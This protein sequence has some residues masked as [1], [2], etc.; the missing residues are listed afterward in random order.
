MMF[1]GDRLKP[2]IKCKRRTKMLTTTNSASIFYFRYTLS[3]KGIKLHFIETGEVVNKSQL[4][5]FR[6]DN[7]TKAE[8]QA[9]IFAGCPMKAYINA[10]LS[11]EWDVEP[12]S[13]V[14]CLIAVCDWQ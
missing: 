6:A 8:R 10:T 4:V 1:V 12:D 5:S 9:A 11:G 14:S 13:F 7:I 3:E 2:I